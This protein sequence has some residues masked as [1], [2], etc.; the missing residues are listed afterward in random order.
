MNN[1]QK[2]TILATLV[3]FVF[4]TFVSYAPVKAAECAIP[5]KVDPKICL[6]EYFGSNDIIF[7]DPNAADCEVNPASI[8]GN[9]SPLV[10]NDNA[11]KIF[12]YLIDK[13]LTAE[14][15]AG[16]LGNF[17][18]ESGFDPAIIQG[19]QIAGPNYKPVNSIGFGI[20]QWTFTARQAPLVSL[21]ESSGR[22]VIDL[23]A[24]LDFLWQELTTTHAHA[25]STLK[26]ETTP[27]RAAYV[28]HRDFEGSADSEAF[29]IKVRGGNA[30]ALYDKYK[31]LAPNT[32][33][34]TSTAPSSSDCQSTA[35][36]DSSTAFLT[37]EFTIYTQCEDPPYG[38]SWGAERTPYGQTMC[39][40][41]SAPTALAMIAKNITGANVTPAETIAYYTANNYWNASG[42]TLYSSISASAGAF[43]LNV[44]TIKNKGDVNAYKEVFNRGG[45]ISVSSKG[46]SPFLPQG[47]T[48]VLRG[49]TSEGKFMIADP[50]YTDTNTAPTNQISV[51][52]ILSDIR[53]DPS[54]TSFAFYTQ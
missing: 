32:T 28:F 41:A 38:G 16:I 54:S 26:A 14:Q 19:G 15:A 5:D 43:K 22:S 12:T 47:H 2:N 27:E 50:G 46:S 49:I 10:G 42:G 33:S 13:G 24:Q 8:G 25:L 29:V 31:N 3:G 11:E 30:R 51:D 35:V 23:S 53:A 9:S 18:Q 37:N 40:A 52:K 39:E 4:A 6:D 48:I 7:Y 20:A 44:S 36:D 45:L 1:I 21:A 34:S 17:Q